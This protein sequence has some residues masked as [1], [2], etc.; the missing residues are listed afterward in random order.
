LNELDKVIF[1]WDKSK[2][3]RGFIKSVNKYQMLTPLIG[4]LYE[5]P[6]HIH[7][8]V[9][10]RMTNH[11]NGLILSYDIVKSAKHIKRKQKPKKL[12]KKELKAQERVQSTKLKKSQKA[13]KK[14]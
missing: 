11:D 4:Y 9:P 8:G 6:L 3:M 2:K 13:S 14:A 10:Y 5:L 12:S 7:E 1:R